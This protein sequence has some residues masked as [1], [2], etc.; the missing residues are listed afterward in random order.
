[1]KKLFTLLFISTLFISCS[2][3]SEVVGIEESNSTDFNT[4]F[5]R[6]D[7]DNDNLGIY[8]GLITT[9]N[10]EMR[11]TVHLTLNGKSAPV[12]E[13]G[14]PSGNKE[15]VRST[16]KTTKG[17]SI[18]KM[19]F[20][21]GDFKFNF[22][23][24]EDGSNPVMS[25]ITY[26]GMPA[27]ALMAKET[28]KAAVQAKTG[29]YTCES[30]CFDDGVANGGDD[31]VPHP[32][33][34]APGAMQTFSF[35]LTGPN[36]GDPQD[37]DTVLTIQFVLNGVTYTGNAIHERCGPVAFSTLTRCELRASDNLNGRSGPIRF[38]SLG[39]PDVGLATHTYNDPAQTAS[40][41]TYQ[42]NA[43]YRSSIFGR[44]VVAFK[45]DNTP[46]DGGDCF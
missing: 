41:S 15:V 42:G 12:V 14:Y 32:E 27:D 22:S 36:N 35:L 1:M 2:Q 29:S 18:N 33:L 21:E 17:Q 45:T 44:S 3:D 9:T 10:S 28:S 26:K 5:E 30:G 34:G 40:C 8:K 7:F 46:G 24:D 25:D 20:E 43:I 16:E 13:F 37:P 38:R 11:A 6:G 19:S 4:K 23:V 31:Q 39:N